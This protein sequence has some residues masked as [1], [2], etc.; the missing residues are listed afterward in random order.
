MEAVVSKV[1]KPVVH[2]QGLT[3]IPSIRSVT[4]AISVLCK[5][6]EVS[7]KNF[8]FI[9]FPFGLMDYNGLKQLQ[10]YHCDLHH[11]S[12]KEVIQTWLSEAGNIYGINMK[13]IKEFLACQSQSTKKA[14]KFNQ[15]SLGN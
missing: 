13:K 5:Q 8:V 10:L 14:S 9:K 3:E 12:V 4:Q 1:E 6:T 15:G 7:M 11:K 2:P